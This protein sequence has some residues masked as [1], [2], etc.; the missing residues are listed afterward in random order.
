M[1]DIP[2]PTTPMMT[3][4]H[5]CKMDAKDAL[6]LFRLGDFYEA[7]HLDAEI[8]SKELGLTLTARQAIPMCGIP[9]HTADGYIDKLVAK[10]FK[11]AVA[12]QIGDA[13]AGKG[14]V[15]R[16]VVRIVTP[17]TLTYSQL[18]SDKQNNFFASISKVGSDFGL[19]F[20]DLSTGEFHALELAQ[21]SELVNELIRLRPAEFLVSPSFQEEYPFLLKDLSLSFPF[22]VNQ[23]EP[24]APRLGGEVLA[25]HFQGKPPEELRGLSAA[26]SAAGSLLLYLKEEMNLP[27]EQIL[28]I[29]VDSPSQYMGLDRASLRNLELIES[30]EGS[31]RNT[32]LDILD[33]TGTPMGGRMLR[34]WI[35]HPLFSL[36]SILKRQESV[37][38]FLGHSK[39]CKELRHILQG[40]RDLERLSMRLHTNCATPRDLLALG[41]SLSHLIRFN[42]LLSSI[43]PWQPL[44][45]LQNLQHLSEKI[46]REIIENPPLRLGDGEI[47]RD[48]FHVKLDELRSLSKESMDHLARYQNML[49]EQTGIKTLKVGF[50]RAFGYYIEVSKGQSDKI[51]PSFH[52]RQTLVSG[53]RFTT[54][55]LKAFE[56]KVL[57]AEDQMKA[58]E[59]ELFESL[60]LEVAQQTPLLYAI[61]KEVAH[62]DCLLSLAHVAQDKK[63]VLPIIDTSDRFE[64]KGGRH[65]IVEHVVGPASFIGNDTFLNEQKQMMLI[66]GP[67]MAGKSTYIRQVALIALLAQMGSC[68]P[69]E[70]AHI[71]LIDK[72]FSRIGASD[73]LARGQSTFMVEMAE[74][75]HILKNATS[76]SLVLL[77]EIGRGTSTYD[78][79]SIAW[80]VAEYLLTTLKKQAKTLFATH[81]WE[82]TKLSASYS[83][84]ANFQ[85]AI[86]ETPSGITFL[87]KIIPGGT[88][89][90]YGI[91]VAKLAGLPS[92]AIQRAEAMLKTLEKSG[93]REREEEQLSFFTLSPS[94]TQVLT[95]LKTSD[96]NTV[97]P[98]E[99]LEYLRTWQQTLQPK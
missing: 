39:I 51:P 10:G 36:P 48:G 27:C 98:I 54:D 46:C 19:S 59:K 4:W 66:T 67:N 55:E 82:L 97:S 74:T 6:L 1:T 11:V 38:L 83:N 43:H 14:L 24:L 12:E 84:A 77:D 21:E 61:A 8:L 50:T 45:C 41:L 26:T 33:H 96:F 81:Y 85:T 16:E 49:R 30:I 25:C 65:P 7:F 71:G 42:D 95:E 78:G 29:Q 3:Q 88:N 20:L 92:K 5:E 9:F 72:I 23:K 68:V 75:A 93:L 91:H 13:E 87:R 22:L 69:A 18:L 76:R 89:K 53:E 94:D 56:H 63:W 60:R 47:F 32:L 44:D 90:S 62:I 15:K 73:D 52:R 70:S 2:A 37:S 17:G 86:Q 64:I 31:S 99:A 57:S 80:A 34:S 28:S 40:V 35:K 79:I 58:L